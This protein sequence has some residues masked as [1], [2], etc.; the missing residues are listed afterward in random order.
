MIYDTAW[1]GRGRFWCTY[2]QQLRTTK[3]ASFKPRGAPIEALKDWLQPRMA[4]DRP[5]GTQSLVKVFGVT[6]DSLAAQQTAASP[7][8]STQGAEAGHKN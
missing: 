1:K 6:F 3:P 8:T 4:G 5:T 2:T 7:G